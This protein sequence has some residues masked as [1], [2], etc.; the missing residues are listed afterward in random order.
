M[1]Y[2]TSINVGFITNSSSVVCFCPRE[3]WNHP[4]VQGFI[5]AFE[6][7]DGFVGPDMWDRGNCA[8]ILLTEEQKEKAIADFNSLDHNYCNWPRFEPTN[9]DE[10]ILI[11]GDEYDTV[12]TDILSFLR[13][14]AVKLGKEINSSEYN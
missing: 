10:I 12:V 2:T 13:K 4:E 7:D 1:K 14:I 6:I 9:A 5:K 11:Y 8:S 3:V